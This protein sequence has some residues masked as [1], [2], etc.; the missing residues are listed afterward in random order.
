MQFWGGTTVALFDSHV[1]PM[2]NSFCAFSDLLVVIGPLFC[3]FLVCTK[4]KLSQAIRSWKQY[5]RDHWQ[6]LGRLQS[7]C[8]IVVVHN[9][10]ADS[11]NRLSVI[12]SLNTAVNRASIT[13]T[14]RSAAR[15]RIRGGQ[16]PLW[17]DPSSCT[18]ILSHRL[19][20][21]TL[22][23]IACNSLFSRTGNQ[24][25]AVGWKVPLVCHFSHLVS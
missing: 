19:S 7:A 11:Q 1:N 14:A 5:S 17:S 4:F 3:T 2:P 16:R 8:L 6:H 24:Y 21:V 15:G 25:N 9:D 22:R 20:D 10:T 13:A 12:M 23:C 18:M